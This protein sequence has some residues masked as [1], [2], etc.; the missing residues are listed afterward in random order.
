MSRKGLQRALN[1]KMK[2]IA[3]PLSALT[4]NIASRETEELQSN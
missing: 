2:S 3:L 1:T 4:K